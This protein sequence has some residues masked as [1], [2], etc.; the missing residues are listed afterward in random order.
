MKIFDAVG[1]RN[2]I[3][4]DSSSENYFSLRQF[5]FKGVSEGTKVKP[6]TID[7][8]F[9]VA[10]IVVGKRLD[11]DNVGMLRNQTGDIFTLVLVAVGEPIDTIFN[12]TAANSIIENFELAIGKI[13]F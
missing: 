6:M 12:V 2:G 10:I 3:G 5:F 9:R 8:R 7:A 1:K 11:N 4:G 13:W